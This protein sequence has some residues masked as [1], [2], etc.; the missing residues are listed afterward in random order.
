[1]SSENETPAELMKRCVE[2]LAAGQRSAEAAQAKA[3]ESAAEAKEY[4]DRYIA[5]QKTEIEAR[6]R[7]NIATEL[8]AAATNLPEASSAGWD[9]MHADFRKSCRNALLGADILLQEAAK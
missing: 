4:R 7:V 5:W 1:M 9:P 3:D 2:A 8:L 6:F